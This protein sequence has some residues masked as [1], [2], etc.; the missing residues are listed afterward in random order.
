[1]S[2]IEWSDENSRAYARYMEKNVRFDHRRFAEYIAADWPQA[3][4]GGLVLDVAGGPAFLLLEVARHLREPRLMVADS[5]PVMIEI[6]RERAAR[7]GFTLEARLCPAEKLDLPDGCVDLVLCKH[8]LRLAT[9]TDASLR[10]MARVLKPG[11]RAYFIDFNGERPW[12]GA[13]LLQLWIQLTAPKFLRHGFR[14]SMATGLRASCLPARMR[15]AGFA[16]AEIL[17]DG[18]SYLVRAA[19]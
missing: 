16:D 6:G 17:R 14:A 1:M 13:T 11:G 8:F 7:Q 10:E 2:E 15:A 3:P 19:R 12:L 18:V 9:D 5:S 4:A